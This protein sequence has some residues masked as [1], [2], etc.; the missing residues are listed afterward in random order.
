MFLTATPLLWRLAP[1]AIGAAAVLGGFFWWSHHEREVG[2]IEEREVWLEKEAIEAAEATLRRTEIT[3]QHQEIVNDAHAQ[4]SQANFDRD[5][6][7][8]A[9]GRLR[10][11]LAA[12]VQAGRAA[13]ATA[14]G[15][16]AGDPLGVL[17]ELLGRI[18]DAA[19]RYAA[20]ADANRIAGLACVR[21]YEA[22]SADPS[23]DGGRMDH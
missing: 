16:P 2:R 5:L 7:V 18:D 13:S 21:A 10:K 19:G 11:Q 4:V 14:G 23:R 20:E 15:S 6:A 3:K 22:L 12:Y 17:A 9:S 8:A 1:Y